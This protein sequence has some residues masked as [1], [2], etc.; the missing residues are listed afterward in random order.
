MR[1]APYDDQYI[2]EEIEKREKEHAERTREFLNDVTQS[3]L[4]Q[5]SM[6]SKG[7]ACSRT[8]IQREGHTMRDMVVSQMKVQREEK[9]I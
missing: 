6:R 5:N 1:K 2:N 8:Q 4:Q 3:H 9:K 7:I